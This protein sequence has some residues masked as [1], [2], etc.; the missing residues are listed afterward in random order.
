M[1]LSETVSRK[2]V[3]TVLTA[4][5]EAFQQQGSSD[6]RVALEITGGCNRRC[7]NCY[8]DSLRPMGNMTQDTFS[9]CSEVI[10]NLGYTEAY[11]VGGEPMLHPRVVEI[12]KT[13]KEKGIMVILATNGY[14]LDNEET[15]EKIL[16]VV[17]R[18]E[19]SVRSSLPDVHDRIATGLGIQT[20]GPLQEKDD[21]YA[22]VVRAMQVI[23]KVKEATG[24][25]V[26]LAVNHDL[27]HNELQTGA[28]HGMVYEIA[29]NLS[30]EGIRLDGFNVQIDTHFGRAMGNLEFEETQPDK[31]DI[32]VALN[33]LVAIQDEFGINEVGFTD[34]PV[35]SGI[36][37]SDEISEEYMEMCEGEVVPAINPRGEAR[38]NVVE[39]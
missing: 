32:L 23:Q 6:R 10:T 20:E 34:N 3:A 29:K 17:D 21:S 25:E 11:V 12:C 38:R 13:L 19:I 27:Y 36:V 33:D 24:L 22:Q 2:D 9:Q 39:L 26:K 15:V 35:A 31:N 18:I 14:K 37:K 16:P 8:A 28:K 5:L 4:Q 7:P 30:E 1:T